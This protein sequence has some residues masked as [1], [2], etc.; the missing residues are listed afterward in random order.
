MTKKERD[1][2]VDEVL[3]RLKRRRRARFRYWAPRIGGAVVAVATVV[4]AAHGVG[5]L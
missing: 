2:I 5:I 4:S 3:A 1:R